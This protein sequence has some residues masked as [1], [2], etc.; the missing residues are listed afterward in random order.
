MTK[1]I[2]VRAWSLYARTFVPAVA[3]SALL[4]ACG[5]GGGSGSTSGSSQ[6]A[7]PPPAAANQ[8]PTIA[9][10]PATT[11]QAGTAYTF[12]PSAQD[13]DGNTLTF[14]ISNKPSWASFDAQTGRLSGTPADAGS[15]AN[16]VI[17]VSDGSASTNLTA[18]GITVNAAPTGSGSKS[19]T[20]AWTPPT[21]RT[22]GSSLSNLAGYR[23]RYG[24]SASN[25]SQTITVTNPGLTSYVID[26]LSAGTY[27]FVVAA[28]DTS[29]VESNN[30]TPVSKT[31]G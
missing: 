1:R 15:F 8:A 29:G 25:Y 7:A 18:F 9:G 17:S 26:S 10:T 27:Y 23:I 16:I 19:V 12:T 31:I 28:Y 21:A 22:D 3:C 5:G 14:S 4:A 30:S 11:V 2:P 24:T 20:L 13:A 6:G